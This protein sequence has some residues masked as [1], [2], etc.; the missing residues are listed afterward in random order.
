MA[1][2]LVLVYIRGVPRK[3]EPAEHDTPVLKAVQ[4]I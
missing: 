4:E 2:V 1:R 3:V